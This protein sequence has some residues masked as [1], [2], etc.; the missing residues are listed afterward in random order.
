LKRQYFPK[1]PGKII[2]IWLFKDQETYEKYNQELFGARPHTPFGYY[3]SKQHALVMNISTGGGTLV[4]EIV[5]PFVEANFPDCPAWF[6]EGL[7]SLYEQC[8]ERDRRIWGATNWRLA[9]LQ[10]AISDGS[11]PMFEELCATSTSEFYDGERGD[12]YAQARY[13]CYYLQ[14]K[15]LLDRF[16]REFRDNRRDDPSGYATLCRVLGDPDMSEF[17]AAW[18]KYVLRLRFP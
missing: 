16:Y 7:A 12:N 2:D 6:N 15:G 10:R 5:H 8:S 1:D 4:H 17:Q 11:L 13:L 14:D 3:S 9:G 18:E